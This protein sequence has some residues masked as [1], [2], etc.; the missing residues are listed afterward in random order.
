VD[1]PIELSA[2]LLW[3]EVAAR[4]RDAL[5]DTTFQ[6]WFD[7][8]SGGEFEGEA[9]VVVVPNDFTREW[10]EG[11]FLGLVE[12]AVADVTGEERRVRVVVR[13]EARQRETG[14]ASSAPARRGPDGMNPKYTFDSFVIGS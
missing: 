12:A 6:T 7:G 14:P 5:N 8:A 9:F 13:E 2:E 3:T 1:R 4:L 11:H 10:I